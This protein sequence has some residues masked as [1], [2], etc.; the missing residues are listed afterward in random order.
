M[1]C[2]DL[3]DLPVPP[4]GKA[5]WPWTEESVRLPDVMPDGRPWPK[6]S[7]VTP[8]YNYAQFIEETIRSVLLQGYPNLGYILK[9]LVFGY[10]VMYDN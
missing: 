9:S 1:R 8:N 7:I 10:S 3:K 4:R 6:I 5:G 2:P